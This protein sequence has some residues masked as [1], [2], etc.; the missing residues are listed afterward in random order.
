MPNAT[1]TRE[2]LETRD[3]RQRDLLPPNRLE[4]LTAVVVGVGAVGRQVALQLA[5]IGVPRLTLID[6][7]TV[8]TV[9]L[10]PQGFF[11]ADLGRPKVD[12]TA[13]LCLQ[14]NPAV[15]VTRHRSRFQK[16]QA[17]D[18][19]TALF[20]AVDSIT[21]RRFVWEA[22]RDRAG[23]FA[24]ARMSGEVVRVLAAADDATRR[25]YPG[26][27]FSQAQAHAGRCTARSTI[28][29]ANIAAALM[30]EQLSR[31]LRGLPLDADLQLNLFSSE[32]D[33]TPPLSIE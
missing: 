30:L 4:T 27:L 11:E 7:D 2:P 1:T 19:R 16:G 20:C 21:A 12:A 10:A 3:T 33:V 31:W 6:P 9:N 13:D 24:D 26:T 25:H 15:I 8:E 32:L 17:L 5:A 18:A 29:T 28:F 22:V 23:F 14:M